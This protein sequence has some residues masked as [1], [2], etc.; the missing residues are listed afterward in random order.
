MK[1]L[2]CVALLCAV[3]CSSAPT[4]EPAKDGTIRNWIPGIFADMWDS[5][6]RRTIAWSTHAGASHC[7]A[8]IS[9]ED[10]AKQARFKS[11]GFKKSESGKNFS[12]DG[13]IV[14]S[15]RYVH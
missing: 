8:R 11:L 1:R 14:G 7:E 6:I 10:E 13:K 2:L 5:L 15:F 9:V 4:V 3:G 12:L